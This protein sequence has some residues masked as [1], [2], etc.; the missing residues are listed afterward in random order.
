MKR[1]ADASLA[2]DGT[3]GHAGQARMSRIR[4]RYH[5]ALLT[6]RNQTAARA[7]PLMRKHHALAKTAPGPRRRLPEVHRRPA[8]AFR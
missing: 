2:I 3:L 6:G 4:H 5:S 7:G 8:G 1:L